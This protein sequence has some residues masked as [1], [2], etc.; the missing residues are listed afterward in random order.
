MNSAVG[1]WFKAGA[2]LF[3]AMLIMAGCEGPAGVAGAKGGTGAAGPAGEPGGPG[4]AGEPGAAGPAG[5]P[6]A[7]GPAGE[8]GGSG[9][10]GPAGPAGPGGIS[11]LAV[12]AVPPATFIFNDLAGKVLNTVAKTFDLS[13]LVSGGR[14]D[15]EYSASTTSSTMLSVMVDGSML[16]VSLVPNVNF[17]YSDHTVKV[18]VTDGVD[19]MSKDAMVRRNKKP[20]KTDIAEAEVAT[21]TV[22]TQHPHD[23]GMM[24]ASVHMAFMDD[25]AL[26]YDGV[27]HVVSS[28]A[29][30]M[31]MPGDKDKFMV[32]GIKSTKLNE[33]DGARMAVDVD[34][35]AMDTGGL[36]VTH[37]M[38]FKV[39]VDQ[40]PKLT[41]SPTLR[42]VAI[43]LSEI[44]SSP[45]RKAMVDGHFEDVDSISG[46]LTDKDA[47]VYSIASSD[48]KIATVKLVCATVD[49]NGVITTL[50]V[51]NDLYDK[52]SGCD[53]SGATADSE[54]ALEI[55]PLR[56][57]TVSVTVTATEAMTDTDTVAALKSL[58]QSVSDTFTVTVLPQ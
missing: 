5:E 47:L 43:R 7:A 1:R 20:T 2:L 53:G 35:T 15:L 27:A 9:P 14:G 40:A 38:A 22:G 26:T 31:I 4:P 3:I 13:T 36:K 48:S 37:E 33:D 41:A 21:I 34:V 6:G 45:I 42:D 44:A 58:Q 51:D 29:Y 23:S 12:K 49:Q 28:G 8:P 39:A 11:P 24:P 50:T 18:S 52:D 30:L 25:D 17:P 10:A 19:T 16:S 32:K 55:N 46:E 54:A 57:G 56:A